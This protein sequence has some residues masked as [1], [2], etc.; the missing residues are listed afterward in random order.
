MSLILEITVDPKTLISKISL[1]QEDER[2][3]NELKLICSN[4]SDSYTYHDRAF[5]IPWYEL[6]P[7]IISIA[8]IKK[9]EGIIV[10]Y[11]EISKNLIQEIINDRRSLKERK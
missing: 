7:G 11:D 1:N 9:R 6:R 4:L 10:R 5:T 2:V 3:I 8:R